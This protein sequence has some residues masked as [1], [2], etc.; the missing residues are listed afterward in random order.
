MSFK[1]VM[2]GSVALAIL[3]FGIMS[4]ATLPVFASQSNQ[5]NT[6]THK[7]QQ[8]NM[9]A[10]TPAKNTFKH[11]TVAKQKINPSDKSPNKSSDTSYGNYANPAFSKH[12]NHNV[13]VQKRS[14]HDQ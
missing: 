11:M 10:L 14:G 7:Y 2:I 6:T 8:G 12:D 4:N 13:T 5:Q 9:Q 1:I 3:A